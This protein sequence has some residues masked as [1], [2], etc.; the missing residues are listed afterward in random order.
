MKRILIPILVLSLA[1]LAVAAPPP[2]GRPGGPQ[3]QSGPGAAEVLP[4]QLLAQFL[5]LT[6]SQIE[7]SKA[8]GET[9]RAALEPLRQQQL[10]NQEAIRA[11]LE[12]GDSATAGQLMLAN[13]RN[14]EQMKAAREAFRTG[15]EALLTSEQKAKFA[16]YR[17]IVE[18]RRD[19]GERPE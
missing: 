12:A 5:G 17:E 2:P 10:A 8:L 11:A 4:P 7:Q 18:L 19:V 1:T 16:I 6:E 9:L 14:G 13:Y 15:F 3:Q